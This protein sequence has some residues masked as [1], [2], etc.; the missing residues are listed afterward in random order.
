MKLEP[1]FVL[2]SFQLFIFIAEQ[3]AKAG[4]SCYVVSLVFFIIIFFLCVFLAN[5]SMLFASP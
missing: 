4:I 2:F 5:I 3:G 1:L